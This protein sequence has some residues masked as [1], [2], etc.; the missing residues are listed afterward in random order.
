MGTDLYKTD[1]DIPKHTINQRISLLD[2]PDGTSGKTFVSGAGGMGFKYQADQI[3]HTLPTIRH[4]YN[5]DVWTLAQ[6]RGDEHRLLVTPKRVL[7]E[8]NEDLISLL[9]WVLTQ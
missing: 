2:R 5:L 7:S 6:S 9:S 4:R 8:Y 1:T 3:S